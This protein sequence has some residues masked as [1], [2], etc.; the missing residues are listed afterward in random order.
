MLAPHLVEVNE[1]SPPQ[2]C[3]YIHQKQYLPITQAFDS[4]EE[5]ASEAEQHNDSLEI[6]GLVSLL[7]HKLKDE[8]AQL[9]RNDEQIIFP[10][11]KKL[12]I[13]PQLHAPHLPLKMIR[14][15]NKKI[16]NLLEKLRLV[17]NGYM[18]KPEWSSDVRLYFEELFN[19]DQ[20][21]AQAIY[22]KE[23][24]LLPKAMKYQD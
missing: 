7:F 19:L 13:Q 20:M 22:L 1:L 10:L 24:V 18:L 9:I 4:I 12:G 2:L 8:T 5:Y 11:I 14:E 21:I 17:A 15:K 23:N 3:Q 16:L 6:L